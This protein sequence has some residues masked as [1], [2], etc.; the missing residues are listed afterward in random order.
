MVPPTSALASGLFHDDPTDPASSHT[1][2]SSTTIPSGMK[3]GMAATAAVQAVLGGKAKQPT[4]P[5]TLY[6]PY[7]AGMEGRGG[8]VGTAAPIASL[9]GPPVSRMHPHP[10]AEAGSEVQ[11]GYPPG[12]GAY[13]GGGYAPQPVHTPYPFPST[14]GAAPTGYFAAPPQPRHPSGLAG[15]GG[16]QTGAVVVPPFHHYQNHPLFASGQLSPALPPPPPTTATTEGTAT[17]PA[18]PRQQ[19][20]YRANQTYNDP[21]PPITHGDYDPF[22][23]QHTDMTTATPPMAM[24]APAAPP[25]RFANMKD[26]VSGIRKKQ[27]EDAAAALEAR[28]AAKEE[29]AAAAAAGGDGEGL[30]APPS[31]FAAGTSPARYIPPH[32]RRTAGKATNQSPPEE[33][34]DPSGTSPRPHYYQKKTY[35][36]SGGGNGNH[37]SSMDNGPPPITLHLPGNL[38][39]RIIGSKGVAIRA[40]CVETGAD[41]RIQKDALGSSLA[42]ISGSPEA[43]RRA[44]GAL[45]Y[46]LQTSAAAFHAPPLLGLTMLETRPLHVDLSNLRVSMAGK[47]QDGQVKFV[48]H[49]FSKNIIYLGRPCYRAVFLPNGQ[50]LSHTQHQTR[51][52]GTTFHITPDWERFAQADVPQLLASKLRDA[53][54]GKLKLRVTFGRQLFYSALRLNVD[55]PSGDDGPNHQKWSHG[56][57]RFNTDD[58]VHLK[59]G[60]TIPLSTWRRLALRHPLNCTFE[61]DVEPGS[62]DALLDHL[63]AHGW[64]DIT[65]VAGE[66]TVSPE[67]VDIIYTVVNTKSGGLDRPVWPGGKPPADASTTTTSATPGGAGLAGEET[68]ERR[69]P[70]EARLKWNPESHFWELSSLHGHTDRWLVASTARATETATSESS[71]DEGATAATHSFL[72][73]H[74]LSV[75]HR[76]ERP[77]AEDALLQRYVR[78]N[79]R[80]LTPEERR[81]VRWTAGT[82]AQRELVIDRVW[83]THRA[84][85]VQSPCG[86]F[87]VTVRTCWQWDMSCGAMPKSS[88]SPTPKPKS[89]KKRAEEEAAVIPEEGLAEAPGVDITGLL[90][91]TA[92]TDLDADSAKPA[93]EPASDDARS[94]T[95][96]AEDPADPAT[97]A[98][99]KKSKKQKKKA[100]KEQQAAAEEEVEEGEEDVSYPDCKPFCHVQ[101]TATAWKTLGVDRTPP[102]A[103]GAK[104]VARERVLDYRHTPVEEVLRG[105]GEV[106]ELAAGLGTLLRS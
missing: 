52:A 75:L 21:P 68:E 83:Y 6:R 15:V 84:R 101:L 95:P 12:Y 36:N 90:L 26:M 39:G 10:P 28:R 92:P 8:G 18:P 16:G 65:P 86:R 5:Q 20:S 62:A 73:D 1:P 72:P 100:K 57:P 35:Y 14:T 94:A 40:M 99:A 71:T 2:H 17:R 49:G 9:N 89:K 51:P 102:A 58:A 25:S 44:L 66:G 56:Q 32:Q 80:Y 87:H 30:Q 47:C 46:V 76:G 33:G 31:K 48:H 79:Q 78:E 61:N 50:G 82:V 85:R 37:S 22:S 42:R 81:V 77:F 38:V 103:S 98:A 43:R 34:G 29:A 97:A 3:A 63:L 91:G 23:A 7:L 105:V 88:A 13:Y 24:D 60:E 19:R 55:D 27:A 70:R 106:M 104:E 59:D 4:P 64:T 45:Y 41:V 67:R 69:M 93:E 96:P 11:G 53:P 74:R 54:P